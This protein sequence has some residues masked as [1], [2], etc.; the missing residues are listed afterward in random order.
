MKTALIGLLAM[1]GWAQASP[2]PIDDYGWRFPVS[3]SADGD[4]HLME[5]TPEIYRSLAEPT[6]G[7]LRL[8]DAAG[9][10][11][12]FGALTPSP[13]D[14]ERGLPWAISIIDTAFVPLP[15]TD[16]E[17]LNALML[18]GNQF[19][20]R[21]HVQLRLPNTELQSLDVLRIQYTGHRAL[22]N[23]TRW[24]LE[25]R[26]GE[27]RHLPQQT[28]MRFDRS[29]GSGE[30][31]LTFDALPL[32]QARH[33][34]LRVQTVPSDLR[35]VGAF[36]E[37]TPRPD[38]HEA[39][40]IATP[41]IQA[42]QASGNFYRID[43][44]FP[45]HAAEIELSTGAALANIR[46]SSRQS[47]RQNPWQYRGETT[48]FDVRIERA[49]L[50]R[51][52]LRM[53]STRDTEWRLDSAPELRQPPQLRLWYRPD[54]F[55]IAHS[56]PAELMLYA[57]HYADRR[58]WYPVD[59]LMRDLRSRLG[60][61]WSPP[62][63]KLGAAIEVRGHLA[64]QPPPEPPPYRKWLLWTALILAVGIITWM[65]SRLMFAP[66]TPAQNDS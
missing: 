6:L 54:R 61:Q 28:G 29:T 32:S 13:V 42:E 55:L 41:L 40:I 45:I 7:D 57:G 22:P 47:A 46:L 56:G 26:D 51:G 39:S 10:E 48:V 34:W 53:A 63:A 43:G 19:P 21:A 12:S 38:L 60:D 8:I 1:V 9:N 25:S 31:R 24:W 20:A 23:D 14:L 5:L 17:T 16:P 52:S 44:F 3:L 33:L 62:Q 35:I 50:M 66:N 59:T 37:L 49:Q 18:N 11:V 4:V 65:A 15:E 58:P 36:A 2:P 64:L 27:V 30:A